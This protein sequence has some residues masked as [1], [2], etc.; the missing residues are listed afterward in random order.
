MEN[1]NGKI[2]IDE[3]EAKA[4]SKEGVVRYV[5]LISI[6]LTVIAFAIIWAT[7]VL[8]QSEAESHQNAQRRAQEMQEMKAEQAGGTD[9]SIDGVNLDV[10]D[11]L[12]DTEGVGAGQ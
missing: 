12:S 1:R 9:S 7:G 2:R 10:R 4:G 6:A 5:L 3:T 8:S 11:E